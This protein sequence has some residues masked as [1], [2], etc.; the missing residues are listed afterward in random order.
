M[1]NKYII[2]RKAQRA[3]CKGSKSCMQLASCSL[4]NP[5]VINNF[6]H[7]IHLCHILFENILTWNHAN[8]ALFRQ[9]L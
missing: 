8:G 9:W 7:C 1:K 2:F 3:A 4:A 5:A 6:V